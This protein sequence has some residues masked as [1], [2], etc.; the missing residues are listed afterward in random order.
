MMYGWKENKMKCKICN[1][2]LS[3]ADGICICTSCGN[4]SSLDDY[5]ENIDVY[6]CYIDNDENGRR[7]KDSIISQDIYRKFE[8]KKI[9]TFYSRITADGLVGDD[10]EKISF[11]ALIKSKILVIVGTTKTYF[12][13][14]YEKYKDFFTDK[15]VIPVFSGI[16]ASQIPQN[17]SKIQAL[18]YDTIGSDVTLINSVL[19]ALGRKDETSSKELSS[20][21]SNKKLLLIFLCCLSILAGVVG[22]I[23]FGTDLI[24]KPTVSE[25]S[26]NV[27]DTYLEDY[28]AAIS[29]IKNNE[30][31]EAIEI[32]SKLSG[33]KDSDKQLQL[34]Y[35]KYAGYYK[36]SEKGISLHFQTYANF[37]SSIEVDYFSD[38]NNIKI[39]ESASLTSNEI[40]YNFNDSENNQGIITIS[41]ENKVLKLSIKTDEI[42]S[43]NYI[44][45]QEI[46]FDLS[47]KSDKPILSL[48]AKTL[49]S[50]VKTPTTIQDVKRLG[51]DVILEF[52]SPRMDIY[53]YYKIKNTDIQLASVWE[54]INISSIRASADL[55]IPEYIGQPGT[56]FYIE[57][58]LVIPN[59]T[60][61]G[62]TFIPW[63]NENNAIIKEDTPVLILTE[64]SVNAVLDGYRVS[65]NDLYNN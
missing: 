7:T 8:A 43:E 61:Y 4:K 52:S 34:I 24:I 15:I 48:D 20:K 50:W 29:H 21:K 58:V 9:N 38:G 47:E 46:A 59:A 28:N 37:G 62:N 44:S 1:G 13:K 18:N 19:N 51:Y 65:F 57:D 35:D 16:D 27:S 49:F 12:E 60:A 32:L 36:D 39:T 54:S 31:K 55:L 23:V 41:L 5:F 2:T 3:I 10:F 42:N 17:I 25:V 30:P 6:I 45:N 14:L 63:G 64:K 22:Y 53:E 26:D 11:S 56:P 33:Y 40:I